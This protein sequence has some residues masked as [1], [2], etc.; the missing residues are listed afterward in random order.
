VEH[1]LTILV[2][3]VALAISI[4]LA[5]TVTR[6]HYRGSDATRSQRLRTGAIVAGVALLI[7]GP[8]LALSWLVR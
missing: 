7:S 1:V 5:I 2:G 8:F 3:V 6:R 4:G